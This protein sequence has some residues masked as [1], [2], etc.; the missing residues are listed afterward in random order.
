MKDKSIL[1]VKM[2]AIVTLHLQEL[3][4]KIRIRCN[5]PGYLWG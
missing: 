3:L 4:K 2:D 5:G 1:I